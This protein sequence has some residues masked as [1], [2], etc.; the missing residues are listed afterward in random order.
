MDATRFEPQ[1][2]Q[3]NELLLHLRGLV[4]VRELLAERG[5]SLGDLQEHSDE[6]ERVRDRLARLVRSTGGGAFSAAA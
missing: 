5:A 2:R 1:F 6:I 3:V 4:L